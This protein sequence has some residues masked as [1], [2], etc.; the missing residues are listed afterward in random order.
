MKKQ[1]ITLCNFI[2]NSLFTTITVLLLLLSS[3][4]KDNTIEIIPDEPTV[5]LLFVANEGNYGD[6]NGSISVINEEGVINTIENVGDVVQS[7]LVHNDNLFVIVNNSHKIKVFNIFEDGTLTLSKVIDTDNSSPR[8]MV[9]FENKLY[10]TNWNTKDVKSLDLSTL[11]IDE[12]SMPVDGLPESIVETEG[13]LFVGIMMNSDYSDASR[14]L[15]IDPTTNI[16]KD[17]VEVGDGP[18]NL[19]I[20]DD[21]IYVARTYYDENWNAF[22][23]TSTIE[24]Y[25]QREKYNYEEA[26]RINIQNYGG[27]T[28]CG[29]T[30]HSYSRKVYRS[31]EGGVAALNQD[32]TINESSKIGDYDKSN[33]YAVETIGDRVYVGTYDGY[34]KILNED[35]IEISSYEVGIFPG[36][37]EVW[38]Q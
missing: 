28:S 16:I 8:E 21:V 15:R 37:F 6:D 24:D 19:L 9:V 29:G 32:L 11:T 2:K 27:G 7:L 13:E 38:E 25:I 30:V 36:D 23:G 1:F 33:V 14:V 22:H 18:T 12:L 34:V 26:P 20:V 35:N 4:E 31:F 17:E 5:K 10:F 3:C